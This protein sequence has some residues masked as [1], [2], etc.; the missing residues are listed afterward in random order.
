MIKK[1]FSII[2][3]SLILTSCGFTP[4]YKISENALRGSFVKY[5]FNKDN[6][7]EIRQILSKNLINADKSSAKYIIDISVDE[8]ETAVNILSSGSVSK[9]R[10][11]SLI[12]FQINEIETNKIIYKSRTRGFS[13]Y[14]V[15]NS[16]YTNKLLKENALTS[17]LTEAIQLMNVIINSKIN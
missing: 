9:Y 7:Y 12:N 16:E 1:T 17:S 15:S 3:V 6:S 11:E 8:T 5:E 10:V 4:T 14:D 13:N 2:I